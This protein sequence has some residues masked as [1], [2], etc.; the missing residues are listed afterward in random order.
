MKYL[1][2]KSKSIILNCGY[3]KGY[4]V[5]DIV[6]IFKKMK[7]KISIN[8]TKKRPGDV[9]RVY[10]DVKKIKKILNWKPKH[11][12]LKKIMK[13]AFKWEKIIS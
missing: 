9:A 7:K 6:N 12:D 2:K 11:D 3:G 4:S 10:A 13:S 1:A 8:F 5:L